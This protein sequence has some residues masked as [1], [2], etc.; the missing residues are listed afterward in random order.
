[1]VSLAKRL[2]PPQEYH[3]DELPRLVYPIIEEAMRV[4]TT[5]GPSFSKI[6]CIAVIM[7][8]AIISIVTIFLV[9][10]LN[11]LTPLEYLIPSV[12]AEASVISGFYS[13]KAKAENKIKLET[14]RLIL[15]KVLNKEMPEG[16][17]DFEEDS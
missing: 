17:D 12:F 15:E 3:E 16:E 9:F 13:Y 1:M 6:L 11:D 14:R 10:Y 2:G 5:R 7:L 8:T 4:D